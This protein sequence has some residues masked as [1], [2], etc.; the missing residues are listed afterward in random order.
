MKYG[1]WLWSPPSAK[2]AGT[3]SGME[4][5]TRAEGRTISFPANSPD[6]ETPSTG[7]LTSSHQRLPGDVDPDR[8]P[9]LTSTPNGQRNRRARPPGAE[10]R[11]L[12]ATD[13][14][15]RKPTNRTS[16]PG[17]RGRSR[18]VRGS[19][20]APRA[21]PSVCAVA[22]LLASALAT[23]SFAA[24]WGAPASLDA[25]VLDQE[26]TTTIAASPSRDRA[27]RAPEP[28]RTRV[29]VRLW[30]TDSKLRLELWTSSRA[31]TPATVLIFDGEDSYVCEGAV[32]AARCARS[33]GLLLPSLLHGLDSP[34]A[35]VRITRFEYVRLGA[36]RL[37]ATRPCR[38]Y[39]IGVTARRQVDIPLA[40]APTGEISGETCVADFIDTSRL[41]SGSLGREH[42]ALAGELA[43]PAASAR[44]TEFWR[45]GIELSRDMT[46]TVRLPHG[47]T[48]EVL[49][50]SQRLVTKRVAREGAEPDLFEIPRAANG[51]KGLQ[52]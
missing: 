22:L 29:G 15:M 33:R 9:R 11:A 23:P 49:Q 26:L 45:M 36:A 48:S 4:A 43:T 27:Q 17:E 41:F 51:G 28:A 44:L 3:S 13:F 12:D 39:R 14:G 35:H 38:P 19:A 1:L 16:H 46:I 30:V 5:G 25:W 34:D 20:P 47:A 50:I 31:E 8:T 10:R 24:W 18:G 6:P 7:V 42:R 40:V 21:V 2:E 52:Q 32:T 37:A